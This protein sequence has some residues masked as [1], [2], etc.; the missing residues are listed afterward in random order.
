LE[1]AEQEDD[2]QQVND[3]IEESKTLPKRFTDTSP[4]RKQNLGT[5][6]L[7]GFIERDGNIGKIE[8]QGFS[9]SIKGLS[10]ATEL[11][12][13]IDFNLNEWRTL[14]NLFKYYNEPL[15]IMIGNYRLSQEE[16]ISK[17]KL[18]KVLQ[19][20]V[21][22]AESKVKNKNQDMGDYLRKKAISKIIK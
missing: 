5:T 19:K 12:Q 14:L 21:K 6:S 2:L 13:N 16:K 7:S 10:T 20:Y 8:V 11:E 1:L 18:V 3:S 17:R 9:L 15:K 4:T 22:H